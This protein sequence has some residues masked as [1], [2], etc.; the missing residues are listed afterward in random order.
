[1][2]DKNTIEHDEK[3]KNEYINNLIKNVVAC[4]KK[5][6][7]GKKNNNV[8]SK[9]LTDRKI[10]YLKGNEVLD[11]CNANNQEN[12]IVVMNK[13]DDITHF[14]IKKLIPAKKMRIQKININ[15]INNM[16]NNL[17]HNLHTDNDKYSYANLT[18]SNNNLNAFEF[19]KNL[20]KNKVMV[21]HDN[22]DNKMNL[23]SGKKRKI[24]PQ[25]NKSI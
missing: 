21:N 18:N 5:D 8:Q 11:D 19:S 13:S 15:N 22:N 12:G 23:I 17:N 24:K 16:N 7:I 25:I 6:L 20:I 14:K 2:T 3:K 4:F 1:M 9:K 10:D